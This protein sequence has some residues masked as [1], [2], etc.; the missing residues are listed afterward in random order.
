M[1]VTNFLKKTDNFQTVFLT[2]TFEFFLKNCN[3]KKNNYNNNKTWFGGHTK[4]K[5]GENTAR[6]TIRYHSQ[7]GHTLNMYK[8][9]EN[10]KNLIRNSIND[11]KRQLAA[12]EILRNVK[13]TRAK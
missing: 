8:I 10:I 7:I 4:R 9:A 12:E 11:W 2:K 3:N 1:I 5:H 6:P 13:I